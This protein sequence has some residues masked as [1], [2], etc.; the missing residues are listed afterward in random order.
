MKTKKGYELSAT[1]HFTQRSIR[2]GGT[3]YNTIPLLLY[4]FGFSA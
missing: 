3:K 1:G 2:G 4:L